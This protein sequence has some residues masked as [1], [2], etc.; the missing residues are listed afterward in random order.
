M[1]SDR[2]PIKLL[3]L[4]QLISMGA[5]EMSG[6]FWP[7][8]IKALLR[9]EDTRYIGLLSTIVYAGPL[10]AAMVFTPMWGRLGDRVGHKIMIVRALFALALCQGL[11]AML[12]DAWMLVTV[13][14][15]Q[16]ALAGFITAAQAYAMVYCPDNS[17]GKTL[18][19]LQ[20][21][22]AIGSL[23]GP[24]LG[25][26]LMQT[27]DFALLCYSA[28][29]ICLL[30]AMLSLSLPALPGR[31]REL[32]PRPAAS[33]Q[34]RWLSG[35]LTII[36]LIQA[37]KLMPQP[38]Y[39]LYVIEILHGAPWLIGISYAASAATLAISAPVWGK[40]FDRRH[41]SQ[42]LRVI[43]RVTWLCA[44]TLAVSALASDWTSF[45]AS[46]LIW[47]VWQ[48]ALLPVAY[49]LIAN[50]MPLSE[51]GFALGMG[52]STA[53]AGA[54]LGLLIGGLGISA[55]GLDQGFWLVA[56]TYAFAAVAIRAVRIVSQQS[57]SPFTP[58]SLQPH[59]KTKR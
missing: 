56:L 49:A 39:A 4:I 19:G 20:S 3:I 17:R 11:A 57:N 54:L 55:I 50:T 32:N 10:L 43:E 40:L 35:L 59:K 24:V 25:G 5:M 48:G 29:F 42:T 13:R 37:A 15:A 44:A 30:C 9:P 16:G 2:S 41:S 36:V 46:R 7:L 47:G 23:M 51:H 31:Q 28:A 12:N 8:Q 27:Q 18:A 22:T 1:K 14:A 6:P 53:K 34:K 45:I 58:A 21:A 33:T 52:N 38:F 26:W